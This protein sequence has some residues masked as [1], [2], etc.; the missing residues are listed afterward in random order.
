MRSLSSG[1]PVAGRILIGGLMAV[2]VAVLQPAAWAQNGPERP[3]PPDAVAAFFNDLNLG[4]RPEGGVLRW[5]HS[6]PPIADQNLR[7]LR[8]PVDERLS[9]T[10][11]LYGISAS[12][13]VYGAEI[14]AGIRANTRVQPGMELRWQ[15]GQTAIPLSPNVTEYEVSGRYMITDWIGAGGRYVRRGISLNQELSFRV[16]G[17]FTRRGY[18]GGYTRRKSLSVFVPLRYSW[19]VVTLTGRLGASIWGT[20]YQ[21]YGLDFVTYQEGPLQ[22]NDRPYERHDSRTLSLN[23]QYLRVGVRYPVLGLTFGLSGSLARVDASGVP[24]EWHPGGQFTV[25]IPF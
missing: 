21:E 3:D 5:T 18:F 19:D 22:P 13:R 14:R 20:S 25:G 1:T 2:L 9:F 7:F 8:R 17:V 23:R 24:T 6:V 11:A 15:D 4:V 16:N 12:L 10:T